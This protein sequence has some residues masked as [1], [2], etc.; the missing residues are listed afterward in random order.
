[1]GACSGHAPMC[2]CC[3]SVEQQLDIVHPRRAPWPWRT[4]RRS[5]PCG[6]THSCRPCGPSCS[7][8]AVLARHLRV[9]HLEVLGHLGR[10]ARPSAVQADEAL[11][12][13]P[14][15]SAPAAPACRAPGS[16]VTNSTCTWSARAQLL[17]HARHFGHRGRADVGAL[18]IAEEHQHHLALEVG[19]RARLAGVV[20]QREVPREIEAGQVGVL[21][22]RRLACR[23]LLA[24]TPP[25]SESDHSS[26]PAGE[27]VFHA[28][29]RSRQ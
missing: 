7:W 2:F 6:R 17:H 27:A 20:G 18:R 29:F 15:R 23:R 10:A 8:S 5:W 25:S 14:A 1:M 4:N 11:D 19:Q 24:S 22:L 26:Q 21:E 28:G 16:T 3:V 9:I 13:K 12:R